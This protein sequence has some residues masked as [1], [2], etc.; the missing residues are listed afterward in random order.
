[1]LEFNLDYVELCD[2]C[3]NLGTMYSLT[4]LKSIGFL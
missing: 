3:S 1:M 4:F 2:G